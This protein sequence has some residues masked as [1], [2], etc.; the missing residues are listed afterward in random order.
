MDFAVCTLDNNV[1][2]A[3]DFSKLSDD[4]IS[5]KRKHLI[6]KE[7][8]AKAY[9]KKRSKSGQA[10]CFG[11]RPHNNGCSLGTEEGATY[12][13]ALKND[14]KE[15]INLGNIINVDFNFNTTIT[16]HIDTSNEDIESKTCASKHS[17]LNGTKTATSKR[18]LKS[19]LNIL[20]NDPNFSKSNQ[21]I[22]I[23]HQYLYN[24]STIFR[25]FEDLVD[26]DINKVRGVYG[27]IFDV[28]IFNNDIWIN[29]GGYD[30]CSIIIENNLQEYFYERFPSYRDIENLNGVYV[31][32]F[33][34]VL[35]SKKNKFYIKLDDISKITFK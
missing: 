5:L 3:Y 10:A 32:C 13:G 9:F 17:S 8:N 25:K 27:Q 1:Y 28:N 7:C 19:L 12:L 23:G 16:T 22:D 26:S 35:K 18:K 14:E 4:E 11:A 31:L 33:G 6:C 20:L 29:S 15:L 34:E 30:D 2:N 21:K 24:A